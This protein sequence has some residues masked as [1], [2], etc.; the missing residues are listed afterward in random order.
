[1]YI[2]VITDFSLKVC[3]PFGL[4]FVECAIFSILGNL[5]CV[6]FSFWV[7]YITNCFFLVLMLGP[8]QSDEF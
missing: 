6:V 7:F 1:M 5:G 3:Y 8:N 2:V 4:E